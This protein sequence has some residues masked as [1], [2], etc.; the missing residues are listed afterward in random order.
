MQETP[1]EN[2]VT[3]E[4]LSQMQTRPRLRHVG[5]YTLALQPAS[6]QS[7][8]APFRPVYP[9]A[10]RECPSCCEA[11]VLRG[12]AGRDHVVILTFQYISR[13]SK[14]TTS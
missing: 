1:I 12:Q 3:S 11:L 9:Q 8:L 13:L 2:G 4:K 5:F 10:L 6:A 7:V 14:S